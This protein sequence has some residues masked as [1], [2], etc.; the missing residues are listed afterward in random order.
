MNSAIAEDANR[1]FV[2][3]SGAYLDQVY[4]PYQPTAG[5]LAG[6]HQYDNKL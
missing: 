2:M 5:T 6:Y 1:A 3:V 4:F